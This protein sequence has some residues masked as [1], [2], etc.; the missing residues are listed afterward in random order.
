MGLS[1]RNVGGTYFL[2]GE[3]DWLGAEDLRVAI[4]PERKE[5]QELVLD[6]ADVTFIDSIGVRSLVLLSRAC[7]GIVLRYPQDR[8]LRV[9]ELLE[10]DEIPGIRVEVG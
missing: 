6:L 10:V 1:I 7:R 9:F 4:E 5:P 8:L 3:L 2:S